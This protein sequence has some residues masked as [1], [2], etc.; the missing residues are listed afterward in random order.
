[1]GLPKVPPQER[2]ED[3]KICRHIR[4]LDKELSQRVV[5]TSGSLVNEFTPLGR[6]KC[7]KI[8][9]EALKYLRIKALSFHLAEV[10]SDDT[11][12]SIDCRNERRRDHLPSNRLVKTPSV[13]LVRDMQK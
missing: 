12:G 10:E 6:G 2:E 9:S 11:D 5:D 3:Q 13:F 7:L 4:Q 1:M 8:D